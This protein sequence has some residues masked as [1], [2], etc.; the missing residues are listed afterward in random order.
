MAVASTDVVQEPASNGVKVDF[1]F[2]FKIHA[3]TDLAVRTKDADGVYSAVLTNGVDYTVVFDSAAGTGTVTFIAPVDPETALVIPPVVDGA[4]NIRRI[5]PATQTTVLP[6]ESAMF[7]KTIE[8]MVDKLVLEMQE[9]REEAG[10]AP[11]QPAQPLSP[12]PIIVEV[13]VDAKGLKWTDNGD[14]TWSI[15]S[16]DH[17][18]DTI[19]DAVL[20]SQAA[21]AASA[22]AA[23]ASAGAALASEVAA[24]ASEAAAAASLA[25]LVA[26]ISEGLWSARP[27]TPATLMYYYATDLQSLE[28]WIPAAGKWFVLG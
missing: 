3:A 8:T 2:S 27:A 17:D 1:D 28:L 18:I 22:A 20:A 10:R 13:P 16:T 12:D 19:E 23:A 9:I 14:G 4:V 7:E 15:E 26:A 11:L 24:A 21:S 6:R 5:S 25:S